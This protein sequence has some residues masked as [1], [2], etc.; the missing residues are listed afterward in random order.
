MFEA[1]EVLALG[2][3]CGAEP[4]E[5]LVLDLAVEQ[6]VAPLF[7]AFDE[8]NEA[9]LRGV[10]HAAEHGLPH[11]SSSQGHAV[12]A[13]DEFVLSVRLDAVGLACSVELD[14]GA[15]DL[16]VDPGV[17]AVGARPDDGL[18]ILIE[19]DLVRTFADD[20]CEGLRDVQGVELEDRAWVGA[21]E[22]CP[23]VAVVHR[24][25]TRPVAGLEDLRR[26][27]HTPILERYA[28]H[29]PKVV[30]GTPPRLVFGRL[31]VPYKPGMAAPSMVGSSPEPAEVGR[32]R[33][34]CV[35][36]GAATRPAC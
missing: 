28:T 11:E 13:T 18:K 7:Q 29:A 4:G 21:V 17:F 14:K 10:P 31:G 25:G 5:M 12:E 22:P 9:N 16:G 19:A 35:C 32:P 36:T 30:G 27:P 1:L 2:D 8:I 20:P 6:H 33:S 34:R 23:S 26:K 24:E 15:D 3:L